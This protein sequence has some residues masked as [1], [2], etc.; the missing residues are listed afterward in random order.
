MPVFECELGC[1]AAVW[2]ERPVLDVDKEPVAVDVEMVG[3]LLWQIVSMSLRE[4]A[5]KHESGH[6]VHQRYRW[7]SN[8]FLTSD[9]YLQAQSSTRRTR[10]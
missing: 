9:D 2:S 3:V 5:V 4:N 6:T 1:R 8:R 7:Q 10:Q